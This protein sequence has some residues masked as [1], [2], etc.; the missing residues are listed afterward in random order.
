MDQKNTRKE[1][2]GTLIGKAHAE[3]RNNIISGLHRPG[4][5][6]RVEHLKRRY[7]VS[8][9]T[10]RE[11]LTMLVADRLVVAEGQRGFRVKPLSVEDL[12]DLS[13]TRVLL[14]KDAIRQSIAH[15]DEEWEGQVASSF[16]ILRRAEEAV[17]ADLKN[18]TLFDEWERRHR[19]FHISLFSAA[20]SEWTRDFLTISYQQFER[21]RQMFMRL[22]Q[23]HDNKRDVSA[24]HEA[25]AEAVLDRDADEAAT[26]LERHLTRTLEEWSEHFEREGVFELDLSEGDVTDTL[27]EGSR[28]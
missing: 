15:G 3:L 6:L 16:H 1:R 19:A 28:R 18:Q 26:L 14:E 22:V 2:S 21:Y 8:S 11:A 25:I 4:E 9:S 24:E 17:T 5:K 10:L 27:G 7:G 13:R 12:M 23:T 20:P